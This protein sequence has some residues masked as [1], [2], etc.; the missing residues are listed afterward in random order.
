MRV[1]NSMMIHSM[2]YWSGK[3]LEKLNDA[4]L[5]VGSGKLINKPSD[6][7]TGT[8]QIL[9]DRA[10]L[11]AYNQYEYNI[12]LAQTWS[13]MDDTTLTSVYSL[14]QNARS[15]VASDI[16]SGSDD[17]ETTAG[18]LQGIYDQVLSMANQ[19]YGSGYM[20]SGHL[21]DIQPFSNESSVTG[22]TASDIVYNL[23]SS[24]SVVTIEISD[25]DGN[26]VRTLTESSQSS[27][28]NTVGWD[29]KDD[30]GNT[31]EDGRYTFSITAAD[32]NGAAVASYAS[33]RG[34]SGPMEFVIGENASVSINND[35][36]SLFGSSLKVLSQLVAALKDASTADVSTG[37]FSDALDGAMSDIKKQEVLLS[38]K[39]NLIT[40][41]AD[42]MSSETV[43]IENRISDIEVGD[44][45]TEATELTAQETAYEVT[46]NALASVLKMPKLSDYL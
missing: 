26:L 8:R 46:Q 28:T 37:N 41:A 30:N 7:P 22:G 23:A 35:G 25:A 17:A 19:L 5:I 39:S 15:A 20:Y 9:A 6:N 34:D 14:L 12:G 36:N 10:T 16:S 44:S 38:G 42:R 45:T 4:S 1:T 3:Q 32:A 18:T 11:S 13:S 27:G 43:I 24:A 2:V 33:Y 31:L 40:A 29:G 21:S